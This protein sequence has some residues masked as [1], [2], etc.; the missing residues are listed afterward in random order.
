ML[1]TKGLHEQTTVLLLLQQL[2]KLFFFH[3][4]KKIRIEKTLQRYNNFLNST[5]CTL[6][7]AY[8]QHEWQR[9]ETHCHIALICIFASQPYPSQV[10]P[11][12]SLLRLGLHMVYNK[13]YAL[14]NREAKIEPA[15]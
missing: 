7:D 12:Q 1:F 14:D 4:C 5:I 10:A 2:E 13:K 6:L 11:Q 3:M 15:K 9:A 8:Y